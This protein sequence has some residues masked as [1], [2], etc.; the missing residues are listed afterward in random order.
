MYYDT[1]ATFGTDWGAG[2][3]CSMYDQFNSTVRAV[4]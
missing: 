2:I 3:A 1:Y 4:V